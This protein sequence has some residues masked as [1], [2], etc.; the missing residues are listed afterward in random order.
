MQN[1][2]KGFTVP[3]NETVE[4]VETSTI[5]INIEKDEVYVVDKAY[6]GLKISIQAF[7]IKEPLIVE[8]ESNV[9]NAGNRRFKVAQE[10]T[11]ILD[12]FE[13]TGTMALVAA[14]LGR[15]S[16]SYEQNPDYCKVAEMRLTDLISQWESKTSLELSIDKRI[17]FLE[18]VAA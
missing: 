3:Q 17:D 13:G 16:I 6:E 15:K 4:F 12:L 10:G 9:I 7:G 2:S 8:K 11:T 14:A 5:N 18:R 1:Q